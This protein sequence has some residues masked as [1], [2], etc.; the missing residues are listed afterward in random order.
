VYGT[1]PSDHSGF[2]ESAAE[3]EPE[4]T[5]KTA[6]FSGCID[7]VLAGGGFA[8]VDRCALPY[9]TTEGGAE[10]FNPIPNSLFPSDHLSL[11]ARLKLV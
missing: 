11:S 9:E 2:G 3:R 4:W 10:A 6:T 8:V 1:D 7:Y 5:T